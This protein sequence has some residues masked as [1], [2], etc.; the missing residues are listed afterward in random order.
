MRENYPIL[1]YNMILHCQ[2][3]NKNYFKK[4]KAFV[5]TVDAKTVQLV[6][7]SKKK[8]LFLLIACNNH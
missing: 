7:K 2:H 8:I 6:K 1:R 3:K 5:I 4:K